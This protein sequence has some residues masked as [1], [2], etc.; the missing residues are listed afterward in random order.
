MG[1]RSEARQ[2]LQD[3]LAIFEALGTV[4]ETLRARAMLAS[5]QA[6]EGV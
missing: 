6:I 4:D 5:A 3:A 2:L 1:E